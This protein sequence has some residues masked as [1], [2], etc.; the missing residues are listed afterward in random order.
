MIF[1]AVNV[2]KD[3]Q[4]P[5]FTCTLLTI[6]RVILEKKNQ[7]HPTQQPKPEAPKLENTH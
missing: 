3:I 2:V 6:G 4:K 7:N 1:E 5:F